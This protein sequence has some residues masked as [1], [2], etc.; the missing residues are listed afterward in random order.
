MVGDSTPSFA[1]KGKI[2]LLPYDSST[3]S[4]AQITSPDG[5]ATTVSSTRVRQ[6]LS[7]QIGDLQCLLG[8]FTPSVDSNLAFA[9]AIGGSTSFVARYQEANPVVYTVITFPFLF[10]VMFGD[11]GHGICLLLGALILIARESRISTQACKLG[12]FMEM[13]FGGVMYSF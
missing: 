3:L 7:Q 11:W 8:Q 10:A 4:A 5:S 9:T 2:P 6:T 13:L 12:S 1:E